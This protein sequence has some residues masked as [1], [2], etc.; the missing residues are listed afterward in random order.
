MQVSFI[1][2]HLESAGP[3]SVLLPAHL[4]EQ[5]QLLFAACTKLQQFTLKLGR[6]WG[7]V[8][9]GEQVVYVRAAGDAVDADAA[10]AGCKAG[11]A[12]SMLLSAAAAVAREDGEGAASAAATAAREGSAASS[13][14]A[15]LDAAAAAAQVAPPAAAVTQT[16]DQQPAAAAV[17]GAAA[18]TAAG[19]W[20]D[21]M[22][23]AL[24]EALDAVLADHAAA[25]AAEDPDWM[26]EDGDTQPP[27]SS[28]GMDRPGAG[29]GGLDEQ[30]QGGRPGQPGRRGSSL[31][32]DASWR[33]LVA[34]R[35]SIT[36][37]PRK[38]LATRRGPP[39]SPAA[40]AGGASG[41]SRE[42][43]MGSGASAGA[44]GSGGSRERGTGSGSPAAAAAAA[45]AAAGGSGGSREPG[46]GSGSPAAMRGARGAARAR[47]FMQ[48][49]AM[50]G[51]GA[52]AG[53]GG[54]NAS[55]GSNGSGGSNASGG[56]GTWR[57]SLSGGPVDAAS[58]GERVVLFA[59]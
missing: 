27:A 34:Q 7:L 57:G 52:A 9:D 43:G 15:A 13:Q 5:V 1:D 23:V 33:R 32:A 35:S 51:A 58:Q 41:G 4:P 26:Q 12:G 39:V 29:I 40:A 36:S 21:P 11:G 28:T 2:L 20:Q 59:R 18:A 14:A 6:G 45:A 8:Q 49:L 38:Q 42:R 16:A 44:A 48:G 46:T 19:S 24:E 53:S 17:A 30:Q 55:G 31:D 3:V 25:A 54:S 22:E 37:S 10:A 47:A 50:R 56:A